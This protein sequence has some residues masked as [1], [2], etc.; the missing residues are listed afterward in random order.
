LPV[1]KI[2]SA[3]EQAIQAAPPVERLDGT[4]KAAQSYVDRITR[5]AWW[6]SACKPSWYGVTDLGASIDKS[7][8][9]VPL[10]VILK[11][12]YSA[13]E[14]LAWMDSGTLHERRG[15][16]YP[17]IYLTTKMSHANVPAIADPWIIL[18]ELAHVMTAD[19]KGHHH[20]EFHR[21]YVK[22]V[23]RYLG[24]DQAKA[25]VDSMRQHKVRG[26]LRL[27]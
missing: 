16:R 6:K 27:I 8:K 14:D 12:G 15:K 26:A 2:Y 22:L 20:P 23:R 13:D 9:A 11:K 1:P 25:L 21:A 18:H 7:L 17:A 10:K 4:L 5:S 19:A 24:D 3:E